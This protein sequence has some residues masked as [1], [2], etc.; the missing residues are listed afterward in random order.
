M[1]DSP[2]EAQTKSATKGRYGGLRRLLLGADI[3]LTSKV[4]LFARQ[5]L[6]SHSGHRAALP[7][8]SSTPFRLG[9]SYKKVRGYLSGQSC[10]FANESHFLQE[11]CQ[12]LLQH[13]TRK[14]GAAKR[15]VSG[16]EVY[17]V[18]SG[19]SPSS[20]M[21]QPGDSAGPERWALSQRGISYLTYHRYVY[22][23]DNLARW[24][25]EPI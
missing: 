22:I 20:G 12:D 16:C 19:M 14:G 17:T 21:S 7:C 8:N 10:P 15:I 4:S 25:E 6:G 3:V 13:V 1:R 9:K 24:R 5:L 23:C 2:H 18:S 11:Y